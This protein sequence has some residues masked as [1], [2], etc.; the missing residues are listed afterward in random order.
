MCKDKQLRYDVAYMKMAKT[1]AELS[2][3]KKKQVGAIIVKDK[4]II[5]DGYNGTVSGMDN[6]CEN[7]NGKTHWHV[8]HAEANAILKL[9][10]STNSS[11]G[12]TL[13]ITL[14]PCIDCTK[15][16]IQAG[17]QRVIY[18]EQYKDTTGIEFLKQNNIIVEQCKIE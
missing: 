3:C 13:Y 12:A 16:I 9:A 1:W 15:L 4:Q 6:N 11:K 10:K 14:S 2:H 5:S 7:C 18:N 17:I 8:L